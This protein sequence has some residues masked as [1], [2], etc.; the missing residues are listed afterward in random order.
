MPLLGQRASSVDPRCQASAGYGGTGARLSVKGADLPDEVGFYLNATSAQVKTGAMLPC[1][2]ANGTAQPHRGVL[3]QCWVW[4]KFWNG[5]YLFRS[6]K[7]SGLDF[8]DISDDYPECHRQGKDQGLR[9]EDKEGLRTS[10]EC[11]HFCSDG[12]GLDWTQATS[13]PLIRHSRPFLRRT[14]T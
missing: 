5:S 1:G 9:G 14:N 6:S 2:G 3:P 10:V 7:L 12:H 4:P 8:A 11:G 13:A